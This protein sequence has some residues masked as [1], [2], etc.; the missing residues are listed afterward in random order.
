MR[1]IVCGFSLL[2]CTDILT[3]INLE[4]HSPHKHCNLKSIQAPTFEY[5]TINI[6]LCLYGYWVELCLTDVSL[7][8]II[9][10]QL[11]GSYVWYSEAPSRWL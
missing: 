11:I 10:T 5:Y 4:L 1:K 6:Y 9:A 2:T 3:S 7:F 8:A